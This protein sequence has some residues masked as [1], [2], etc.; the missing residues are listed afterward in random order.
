MLILAC[1]TWKGIEFYLGSNPDNTAQRLDWLHERGFRQGDSTKTFRKKR[2]QLLLVLHRPVAVT[3]IVA[4][5]RYNRFYPVSIPYNFCFKVK[6]SFESS[7]MSQVQNS[8]ATLIIALRFSDG[9]SAGIAQPAFK[10]NL[11][12]AHK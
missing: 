2:K 11:G 7:L 9:V 8:L 6:N 3:R 12:I 1:V 5:E 10:I 4:V